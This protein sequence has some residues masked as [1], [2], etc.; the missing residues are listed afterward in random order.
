M[1]KLNGG[2]SSNK[3]RC[4]RC[5]YWTLD[6]FRGKGFGLCTRWSDESEICLVTEDDCCI[7]FTPVD[8]EEATTEE[9][10]KPN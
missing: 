7:E 6:K 3:P 2:A 10:E 1:S 5:R 8:T 4:G 9:N